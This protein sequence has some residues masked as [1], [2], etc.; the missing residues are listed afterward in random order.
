DLPV[1]LEPVVVA[2]VGRRAAHEVA[3]ARR[4]VAVGRTCI[5]ADH[6]APCS[7]AR[8][9]IEPGNRP[10]PLGE[11]IPVRLEER[12][13]LIAHSSD[14]VRIVK[15]TSWQPAHDHSQVFPAPG[16]ARIVTLREGATR[17][18]N[19][20][21]GHR[22]ASQDLPQVLRP[23]LR[24]D[25]VP[26]RRYAEAHRLELVEGRG[27][28]RRPPGLAGGDGFEDS[29]AGAPAPSWRTWS[30]RRCTRVPECSGAGR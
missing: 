29:L 27:K 15:D 4:R 5:Y 17:S 30:R 8:F 23:T 12:P 13:H 19:R 18:A 25:V 24:P 26:V 3:L 7:N 6:T 16:A 9:R 1:D 21:V 14:P 2:E 20:S 10:R 22:P 28:S 11:G